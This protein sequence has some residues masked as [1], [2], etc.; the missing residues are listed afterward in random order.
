M[1]LIKLMKNII[2]RMMM[3]QEVVDQHDHHQRKVRENNK[4][5]VV[6]QDQHHQNV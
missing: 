2:S 6:N 1:D 3:I 5:M 4:I